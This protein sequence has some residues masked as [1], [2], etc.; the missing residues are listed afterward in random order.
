MSNDKSKLVI[1][2]IGQILSGKLE[3]PLIDGDCVIAIDG[4]ISSIGQFA[5]LD[6]DEA[7]V[8][9]D[10]NGV[11]LSPGL[12]DSHVHQPAKYTCPDDPKILL[13]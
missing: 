7:D 4:V 5:D 13:D 12:I 8:T 10:A 9:V 3:E 6:T 2:N 1:K 11:W